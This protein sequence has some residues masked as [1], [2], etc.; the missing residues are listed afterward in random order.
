MKPIYEHSEHHPRPGPRRGQSG[1]HRPG[2]RPLGQGEIR[3]L[4]L[5]LIA[6]APGHGYDLIRRIEALSG[7]GYCPSPGVIYPTLSWLEDMDLIRVAA[8]EGRKTVSITA[9]GETFLAENRPEAEALVQR[10]SGGAGHGQGRHN[11]PAPILR[12]MENLKL[13]LRLRLSAGVDETE[14]AAIAAAIDSAAQTI[15]RTKS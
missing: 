6:E 2:R 7:G 1:P 8:T 3:L 14:L 5:G 9:A 13:A 15:E 11:A 10:L 12:A 4:L